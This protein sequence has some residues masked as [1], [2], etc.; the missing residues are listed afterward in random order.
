MNLTD[1]NLAEIAEAMKKR[2][3]IEMLKF[4]GLE[5]SMAHETER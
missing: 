2:G 1:D 4:L 5:T 3:W